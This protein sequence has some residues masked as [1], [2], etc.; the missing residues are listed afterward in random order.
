M[1]PKQTITKRNLAEKIF[2]GLLCAVAL[3]LPFHK[4]LP[5]PLLTLAA[6]I[7]ICTGNFPAKWQRLKNNRSIFVFASLYLIALFGYVLSANKELAAR[8]L[9][10]KI[11]IALIPI[12]LGAYIDLRKKEILLIIRCFVISC[13]LFAIAAL[14]K[15]SYDYFTEGVN[16]FFYTDL[17]EF[18]FIH[19]S[20]IAMF[21]VFA[22]LFLLFNLLQVWKQSP[23]KFKLMHITTILFLA[24]FIFLLSSKMA[25]LSLFILVCILLYLALVP[26]YGK[27]KTIGFLIAILTAGLLLILSLPTTRE[28]FLMLFTYNKVDYANSTDSREEIWKSGLEISGDHLFTGVGSGDAEQYLVDQYATNNFTKGVEERYNAHNQYL[29]TIIETGLM[30]F[31]LFLFVMIYSVRL[32][33]RQQNSIYFIFLFLF[34]INIFTESMFKTQSGVVFYAFFNSLLGLYFSRN[35]GALT[36]S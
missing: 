15:A 7:A 3:V 29:Q 17:V 30:G 36:K 6:L 34:L 23:R 18:T 13:F 4:V 1:E 25:I 5:S 24:F 26:V 16:H 21:E 8:D 19:P 14:S 9:Q 32:A 31:A 10:V 11:S 33:I 35:A 20:Y 27:I 12:I 28:R 2:I 22:L